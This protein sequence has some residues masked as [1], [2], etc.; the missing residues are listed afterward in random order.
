MNLEKYLNA[1]RLNSVHILGIEASIYDWIIYYT[2]MQNRTRNRAQILYKSFSI[3]IDTKIFKTIRH[4]VE[5]L[6]YVTKEY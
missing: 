5:K 1:T 6:S 2:Q 3:S 4:P